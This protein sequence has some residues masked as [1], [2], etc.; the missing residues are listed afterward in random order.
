L[1]GT[2]KDFEFGYMHEGIPNAYTLQMLYDDFMFLT[3]GTWEIYPAHAYRRTIDG[4][5]VHNCTRDYRTGQL[6]GSEGAPVKQPVR[7]IEDRGRG[8]EIHNSADQGKLLQYWAWAGM[9]LDVGVL[10]PTVDNRTYEF[11]MEITL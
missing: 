2:E 11:W 8:S 10:F 9:P 5:I 4:T 3:R 7:I 6:L 1:S